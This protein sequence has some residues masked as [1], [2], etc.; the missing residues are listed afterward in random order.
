MSTED[1]KKALLHCGKTNRCEGCPC[2]EDG[3]LCINKSLNSALEAIV[4]LEERVAIMRESMESL[5]KQLDDSDRINVVRCSECQYW[6][7]P[8]YAEQEDG[9]T[10]GHCTAALN[11][12]QTDAYWFCADGIR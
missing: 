7:P 12:Q 9:S 2:R 4:E 10:I 5:E 3:M 8:T 6:Q 1:V 11:G